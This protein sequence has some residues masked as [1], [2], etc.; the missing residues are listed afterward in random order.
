LISSSCRTGQAKSSIWDSVTGLK[1]TIQEKLGGARESAGQ[2]YDSSKERAGE[3]VD[4]VKETAA[5]D[6]SRNL[7]EHDQKERAAGILDAV[8]QTLKASE[9]HSGQT[10]NDVG[11]LGGEGTGHPKE[12]EHLQKTS[13]EDV[14]NK[15]S[16]QAGESKGFLRSF[17]DSVKG[18]ATG[19]KPTDQ[20]HE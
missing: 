14:G 1:D 18:V 3:A 11:S 6:E 9:D 15:A 7:N 12:V 5:G 8:S 19:N 2:T 16:Q 17:V 20:S 13:M 4:T 10:F